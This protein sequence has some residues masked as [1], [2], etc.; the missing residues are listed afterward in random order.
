M[1]AVS[2]NWWDD[3][4]LRTYA[5]FHTFFMTAKNKDKGKPLKS[6]ARIY[7]NGD[8]LEFYFGD[9]R[10]LKFGELTPDN[11]FTFTESPHT[12]RKMAAVTFSS[13]LYK[14]IPFMWQRIGIAR[15]RVAHT[16]TIPSKT[17]YNHYHQQ[18]LN[19]ME[20]GYMRTTAPEYFA[21][22]KFNMLT[23]ECLN[24]QPELSDNINTEKRKVW[25]A[26][27][28][29]F[30]YGVKARARV[31]ALDA[32]IEIAKQQPRN[33]IPDWSDPE[34]TNL[35]YTS[36]KDN[37]HPT[38]LLQ[39]FVTQAMNTG[40]YQHRGNIKP[41]SVLAVV[42]DVCNTHSVDLRKRFGVFGGEDS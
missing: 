38:E 31:G 30:K 33:S 36:I 22:M 21:G 12:V 24:R 32:L 10:G 3:C 35:L 20:W 5:N 11:V 39:G 25:L 18:N 1:T 28:R 27:L 8:T 17:E 16:S 26:A 37:S 23:G 41:A 13:S 34:W 42:D 4:D 19:S 29:K 14:A 15:Y 2:T 40:W 7:K 9:H 6:W